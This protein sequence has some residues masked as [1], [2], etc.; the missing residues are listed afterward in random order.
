ML[1]LALEFGQSEW[2]DTFAHGD[3]PL[4]SGVLSHIGHIDAMRAVAVPFVHKT[5]ELI[6]KQ[7]IGRLG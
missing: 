1:G 5:E 3:D 4:V 6:P 2:N 7:A